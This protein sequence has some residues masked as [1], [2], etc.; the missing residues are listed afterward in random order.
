MLKSVK[1]K[2]MNNHTA[3]VDKRQSALCF[4]RKQGKEWPLLTEREREFK[5]NEAT[6]HCNR[7]STQ[8][9]FQY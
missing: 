7:E 6:E 9:I 3:D 5:S 1:K 4:Q 2:G 8:V